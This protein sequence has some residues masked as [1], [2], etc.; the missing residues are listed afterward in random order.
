MGADV[1]RGKSQLDYLVAANTARSLEAAPR[2]SAQAREALKVL[3]SRP[4]TALAKRYI[5]VLW[6]R[7]TYFESTLSELAV[8]AG[9]T[10]DAYAA[11]LRRA[12][13]YAGV[14]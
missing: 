10:K 2:V 12:I 6:L 14:S 11:M 4:E 7:A 1:T 9:M 3:R 13:N 8:E 5:P